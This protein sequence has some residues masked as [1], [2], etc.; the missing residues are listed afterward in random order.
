MYFVR[1]SPSWPTQIVRR[2]ATSFLRP[3]FGMALR[4]LMARFK[5]AAANK[6]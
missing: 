4:A 6:V 3:P 5:M 2:K 1:A